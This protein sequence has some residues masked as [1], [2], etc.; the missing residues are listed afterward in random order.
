[1]HICAARTPS[2]CEV[3]VGELAQI[4]HSLGDVTAFF[5]RGLDNDPRRHLMKHLVEHVTQFVHDVIL[6][7]VR[8][9]HTVVGALALVLLLIFSGVV[10][11]W[12]VLS[13]QRA[14]VHMQ[15]AQEKDR[16]GAFVAHSHT[17][18]REH[19]KEKATQRCKIQGG[20]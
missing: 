19:A 11:A 10:E 5:E 13:L 12:G 4:A 17:P 8:A 15:H 3:Q 2:L 7:A 1:M 14:S 6:R 20:L 16:T 18:R 9:V